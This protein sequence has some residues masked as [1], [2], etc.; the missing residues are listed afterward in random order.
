MDEEFN[1]LFGKQ[2]V[3]DSLTDEGTDNPSEV[4]GSE[5]VDEEILLLDYKSDDESDANKVEEDE[6]VVEHITKVKS[7]KLC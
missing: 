3:S 1:Q 2:D 6:C 7:F 4:G 5:N